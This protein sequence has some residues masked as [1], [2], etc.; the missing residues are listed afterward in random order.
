MARAKIIGRTFQEVG[1]N[2]GSALFLLLMA[3]LLY[4]GFTRMSAGEFAAFLG[5]MVQVY[6]PIKGISKAWNQL[7]E[8]KGGYDRILEL[9][10]SRPRVEDAPGALEFPGVREEIRF[11]RVGFAYDGSGADP[12]AP[13]AA[14]GGNGSAHGALVLTNVSF[15]VKVGQV[16]AIV[17][18]S[19]AGK[20]TLV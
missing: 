1:Y 8:S 12:L 10:R 17:G 18:P 3:F 13:A 11:D 15:E 4:S 20:S 9:L 14:A 16:V 19:G 5:A 6:Q 2:V 7:Q